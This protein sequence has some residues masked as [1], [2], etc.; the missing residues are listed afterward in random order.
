MNSSYLPLIFNEQDVDFVSMITDNQI[1]IGATAALGAA[2]L[3][4]L[5]IADK[6][7]IKRVRGWPYI[8]QWVFFTK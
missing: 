3:W 6:S 7:G 5:I 4:Y 1:A 8:G 2:L